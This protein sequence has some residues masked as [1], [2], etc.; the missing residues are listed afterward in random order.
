MPIEGVRLELLPRLT[1]LT[2]WLVTPSK[3]RKMGGGGDFGLGLG[4]LNLR[5][6]RAFGDSGQ[7]LRFERHHIVRSH[8]PRGLLML[9]EAPGVLQGTGSEPWGMREGE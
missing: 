3:M 8:L 4:S 5:C 7:E 9:A 1:W 2:H 6:G